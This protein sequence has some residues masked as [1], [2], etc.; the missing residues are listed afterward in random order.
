ME[1]KYT[2][3]YCLAFM[4]F[5]FVF[6]QLHEMAHLAAAYFVCGCPGNQV[7]FNL[8][9]VCAS[10]QDNPN[11]YISGIA[12]PAFSYLMMWIGYFIL[13]SSSA[14]HYNLAFVLIL[15]NLAFA[16][17]FTAGM[18]GGDEKMVLRALI[19]SP[20]LLAIKAINFVMVLALAFPPLYMVYKRLVNKNRFWVVACFCFIPLCI[21]Y[22]YEFMLLGKVMQAGFLAH[23]G[24]L[25]VADF[26]YLHT[27]I[28]AVVVI[29]FRKTLFKASSKSLT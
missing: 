11:I 15:G 27:A 10:C 12:G 17:I 5:V 23:T 3:R 25:G 4:A 29:L 9:K 16:R 2:W 14:K 28:M 6:G 7:D 24:F 13:R 22:P 8:W 19:T 26:V 20:P 1:I 21:M 18:G